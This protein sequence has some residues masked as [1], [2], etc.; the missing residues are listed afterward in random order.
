VKRSAIAVLRGCLAVL[1]SDVSSDADGAVRV[2]LERLELMVLRSITLLPNDATQLFLAI[3]DYIKKLCAIGLSADELC[4][5]DDDREDNV[6]TSVV[7]WIGDVQR[8]FYAHLE[9]LTLHFSSLRCD[10]GALLLGLVKGL[11]LYRGADGAV[12]RAA[13][14]M[15]HSHFTLV[16]NSLRT[17][18]T[19]SEAVVAGRLTPKERKRILGSMHLTREVCSATESLV[20]LLAIAREFL[21]RRILDV[22]TTYIVLWTE[23]SEQIRISSGVV[24]RLQAGAASL[25]RRL[26]LLLAERGEQAAEERERLFE[27]LQHTE[28][29]AKITAGAC[30]A[31]P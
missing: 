20:E 10:R 19:A 16:V 4:G 15:C 27:S 22:T 28:T 23:K 9:A 18:V 12:V 2:F 6:A 29:L 30:P 14:P 1:S 8:T 13:L 7:R 24:K 3:V 5:D 11:S 31:P 25:V 21:W 26:V 17:S